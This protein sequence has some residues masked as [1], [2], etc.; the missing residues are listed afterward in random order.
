MKAPTMP[1]KEGNESLLLLMPWSLF[2]NIVAMLMMMT[3]LQQ[4]ISI[5]CPLPA[6]STLPL[7]FTL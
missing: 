5:V 6:N 4:R 1:Q 3:T 2:S 7:I